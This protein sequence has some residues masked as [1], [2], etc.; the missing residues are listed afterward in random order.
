M[1]FSCRRIK[2]YI[3][4]CIYTCTCTYT[5]TTIHPD[6]SKPFVEVLRI[7]SGGSA[8]IPAIEP[9]LHPLAFFLK[10]K[11]S[12]M[13]QKYNIGNQEQLAVKLALTVWRHTA[14]LFS[15]L[16]DHRNLEYL[17]IAKWLNS[18]QA[19]RSLFFI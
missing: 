1:E 17:R 2:N 10:L 4:H 15:V 8:V 16:T 5:Y 13:E 7:W 19:H 11:L 9:K 18:C 3:Y 6:I 14:H 12:P